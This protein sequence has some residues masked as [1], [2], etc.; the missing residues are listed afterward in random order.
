MLATALLLLVALGW[1][2]WLFQ[3]VFIS[4]NA[5]WLFLTFGLVSIASS[6]G[7][8]YHLGASQQID[9]L[10]RQHQALK[11]KD[12]KALLESAANKEISIK[13]LFEEVRLR[14]ELDPKNLD[15]W[16]VFARLLLQSEQYDLADQAFERAIQLGDN[17]TLLEVA[18][19]YIDK[20]QYDQAAEKINR[21]LL[22]NPQHEGAL[23]LS[24]I[25]SSKLHKYAE[26]IDSWHY[27]LGLRE[28][29]S[30]S[31]KLIQQQIVVAQQKLKEQQT[32]FIEIHID[33]FANLPLHSFT[34]AFAIVRPAAGGAPIAVKSFAVH[35]LP[36]SIKITPDDLMIKSGNL[37]Q[38]IDIYMEIRLS[39]SGF[40][41]SETGD[42]FGK[43]DIYS[44][45]KAGDQFHISVDQTVK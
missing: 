40:A 43:T 15:S 14:N 42:L 23:L 8:Y 31:A 11:D 10:A 6:A 44:Q 13:Q 5:K 32:N 20:A 18:Q 12:L 35:E 39:K 45:L 16:M 9:A 17:K 4:K 22:H 2:T 34:K 27:L 21:V 28:P 30:D 1:A 25:N 38:A 24:G 33:N 26:A 36:A 41:K 7:L 37:W 19:T 3:G 29:N